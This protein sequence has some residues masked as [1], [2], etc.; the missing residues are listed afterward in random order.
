M[1]IDVMQMIYWLLKKT[2]RQATWKQI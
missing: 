1:C 2:K